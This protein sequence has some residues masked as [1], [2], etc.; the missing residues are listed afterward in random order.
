MIK[1]QNV[2]VVA[3]S[4]QTLVGIL[5]MALLT[6]QATCL[7]SSGPQNAV[8]NKLF[9]FYILNKKL[10]SIYQ[11]CCLKLINKYTCTRNDEVG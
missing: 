2:N 11:H 4:M 8:K 10:V 9:F 1:V 7:Q 6:E 3:W 5:Q